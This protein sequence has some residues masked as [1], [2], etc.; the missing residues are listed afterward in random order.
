LTFTISDRFVLRLEPDASSRHKQLAYPSNV[1]YFVYIDSMSTEN[2]LYV[3][4]YT[5]VVLVLFNTSG[6]YVMLL[7]ACYVCTPL[8]MCSLCLCTY[9]WTFFLNV[10]FKFFFNSCVSRVEVKNTIRKLYLNWNDGSFNN[11]FYSYNY[12]EEF[13]RL[14]FSASCV[15]GVCLLGKA[16]FSSRRNVIQPLFFCFISMFFFLISCLFYCLEG[17]LHAVTSTH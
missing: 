6:F 3:C 7:C 10:L 11:F 14:H 15:F 12:N 1:P 8:S 5:S 2:R 4:I 16:L 13:Y 9:F 17:R